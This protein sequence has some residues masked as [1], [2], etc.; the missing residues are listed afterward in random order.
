MSY[1]VIRQLLEVH[2]NVLSGGLPTAWENVP[3]KPVVGTPYQRANLLPAETDNPTMGVAEGSGTALKRETGV[4]QLTLFYPLNEG[5]GKA[6]ER[7][8]LLRDHYKR[9]TFLSAG[10][11]RLV[12][13]RSPSIG[14]ALVD[15]GYFVVPISVPYRA[16][17][18]S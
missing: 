16:D 17:V 9:G 2:L 13:D 7:A 6:T 15:D 11:V 4:F 3:Y 5:A 8:E 14:R 18:L 12:I 1:V 10:N